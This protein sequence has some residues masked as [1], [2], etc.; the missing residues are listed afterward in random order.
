MTVK[1]LIE[2]LQQE[3]PERIVIISKDSEGNNF[4]PL[5]DLSAYAYDPETIRSGDI[6]IEKLTDE[7][8][9]QG[10]TIENIVVDGQKAIVL[11]PT[12]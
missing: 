12:N 4:S 11:W 1:E 6:G 9:E 7:N 3:D 5:S 2:K 10:Y 8:R